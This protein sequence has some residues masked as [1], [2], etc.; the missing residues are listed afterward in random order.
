MI[1]VSQQ[2]LCQLQKEAK[3]AEENIKSIYAELQDTDPRV[4]TAVSIRKNIDSAAKTAH[5]NDTGTL[6]VLDTPGTPSMDPNSPMYIYTLCLATLMYGFAGFSP[7]IKRVAAILEP[8]VILNESLLF[9]GAYKPLIA[10]LT[11]SGWKFSLGDPLMLMKLYK[12]T[13]HFL[14]DN[15]HEKKKIN[16]RQ[17]Q[18]IEGQVRIWEHE[19]YCSRQEGVHKDNLFAI[20]SSHLIALNFEIMTSPIVR[21]IK[22]LVH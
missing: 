16:K 22:G 17:K 4:A 1:A 15:V 6:T 20:L 14:K 21:D 5:R 7:G 18:L 13:L 2:L 9:E 8:S 3:T 12:N 11:S 19:S 10:K